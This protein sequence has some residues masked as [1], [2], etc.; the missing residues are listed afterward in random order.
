MKVILL[1]IIAFVC[2]TTAFLGVDVSS[3]VSESDWNCLKQNG[4]TYA[5][6]R[7]WRSTGSPDPDAAASIKAANEAGVAT[8]VYF[9]PD[10][11]EGNPTGQVQQA[12]SFLTS[13]S[14]KYGTMW[15][16]I[17]QPPDWGNCAENYNFLSNLTSE[18]KS[19]GMSIGIYVSA[20]F[21]SSMLC[22]SK[23]FGNLQLWYADWD[24]QPNFNNFQSFGG[25]SSPTMKQ[26]MGNGQSCGVGIDANYRSSNPSGTSATTSSKSS[27]SGQASK[28]SS[29]S[30]SSGSSGSGSSPSSGGSSGS[31]PSSSSS[32]PSSGS[33]G[34]SGSSPSSSGSS[35]S[36][37]ASSGSSGSSSPST[38]SSSPS[39]S[40]T[41]SSSPASA[42]SGANIV[43]YGRKK[44]KQRFS[45]K[46]KK[47]KINR[48]HY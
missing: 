46:F 45:P 21:W 10:Y 37:S 3:S 24:N 42:T 48:K 23:D 44:Y 4:Y 43:D 39:S 18:A 31:S 30:P 28:S 13:N 32:S 34:S 6:V 47:T 38:A 35:G 25:W 11:A 36:S 40:R 27:S 9:F 7:A 20:N 14:I 17:E 8:D 33:S 41:A 5:I 29:S 26:Y 16:D 22:N 19:L 12:H 15:I 2:L 1:V